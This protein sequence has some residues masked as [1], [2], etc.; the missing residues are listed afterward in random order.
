MGVS[1][2]LGQ[3]HVQFGDRVSIFRHK[4]DLTQEELAEKVGVDVSKLA[5]SLCKS[6]YPNI[7]SKV[8]KTKLPFK[9][10]SF[11]FVYSAFVLEHTKQTEEF[12]K[13]AVRVLSN[14]GTILFV[15][16]NF[17]SPNR[18]SPNGKYNR[19]T[20]ILLGSLED[21][22]LFFRNNIVYLNWKR[23]VP[24]KKYSEIDA[25][26][27]IEPYLLSLEKYMNSLG[28]KKILSSSLWSQEKKGFSFQSLFRILASLNLYPFMYWGPHLLYIGKKHD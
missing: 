18:I 16:P 8:V 5:I 20:K 23:V 6:K 28:V 26:T 3:A 27:T 17:G 13:E 4:R 19:L 1:Q 11:D 7:K 12:L 9:N 14:N 21:L 15:A 22:K 24:Q 25:D 2:Q 10:N